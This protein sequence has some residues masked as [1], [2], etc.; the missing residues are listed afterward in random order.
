MRRA[1]R[2]PFA[3][4]GINRVERR[5]AVATRHDG[6]VVHREAAVLIPAVQEPL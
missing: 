5:S 2:R 1:E 3:E 4:R 6:P